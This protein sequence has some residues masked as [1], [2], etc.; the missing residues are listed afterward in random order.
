MIAHLTSLIRDNY[1]HY[2]RAGEQVDVVGQ[3][4]ELGTHRTLFRVVWADGTKGI[5]LPVDLAEHPALVHR[6]EPQV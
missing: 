4:R 2:H 3:C 5:A 1:G 6:V